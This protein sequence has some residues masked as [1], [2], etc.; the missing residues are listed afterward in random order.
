[1]QG[2]EQSKSMQ[3]SEQKLTPAQLALKLKKQQSNKERYAAF[4]KSRSKLTPLT[5]LSCTILARL[6]WQCAQAAPACS[7][8]NMNIVLAGGLAPDGVVLK[9]LVVVPSDLSLTMQCVRER[10]TSTRIRECHL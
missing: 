9:F 8:D 6:I 4:K 7:N 5:R 10:Y 1:M 2:S 3:G